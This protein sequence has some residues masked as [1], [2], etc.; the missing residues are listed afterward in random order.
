MDI[1]SNDLLGTNEFISLPDNPELSNENKQEF[2]EYYEKEQQIKTEEKINSSINKIDLKNITFNE[3]TDSNNL[4]NTNKYGNNTIDNSNMIRSTRDVTTLVSVDSRDRIKT[5]YP[6]PNDF[7]IFLG[8][9]YRNVKKIEL[10]SLEFPNTDAVI[11]NNNNMIYW[12]NKEDID[13][14]IT[15]TIKGVIYYPVYSAKLRIGS[16]TVSSLQ[17][18][19]VKELTV[20]KRQEGTQNG[21]PTNNINDFHFFVVNLDI[22][23]DIVTFNSLILLNLA[24][25]AIS[26]LSGTGVITVTTPTA[27]GYENDSLIYMNGAKQVGGISASII[28]G[29]QLIT[30]TDSIT[31]KF[32]LNVNASST[33]FGG[34]NTIQSGKKAPFQLLWGD[35]S[36]TIAQNIGYPLENSSSTIDTNIVSLQNFFQ[37]SI[38]L[39]THNPSTSNLVPTEPDMFF[40]KTYDY[41]G[42]TINIGSYIPN[43]T[44]FIPYKSFLIT[45]VPTT[46]SIL[47]QI[48]DNTVVETMNNS[49][50]SQAYIIQ[51]DNTTFLNV[52]FYSNYAINS[53]LITTSSPH[54]YDLSNIANTITLI[55]TAD[56]TIPND[57]S[58]DGTYI[59][60]QVPSST[61]LAVQGVIGNLNT[62]TSGL[63][64]HL[65]RHNAIST[66][67]VTIADII[68]NFLIDFDGNV[69]AKIVTI[70]PHKLQVNDYIFFN[71]LKSVPISSI[72]S[73]KIVTIPDSSSFLIKHQFVSIDTTTILN[74]TA[75]IGTGLI[76]VSFPSHNFNSII[77]VIQGP[78]IPVVN[79]YITILDG[80]QLSTT[81]TIKPVA[82]VSSGTVVSGIV[83][84]VTIQT[85]TPHNLTPGSVVRIKF[86]GIEPVMGR[87]VLS[88]GY[89]VYSVTSTDTFTIVDINTP[90]PLYVYVEPGSINGI[91]GLSSDFYLYGVETVGGINSTLLNSISFTVR[92]VL[93]SDNF[94]FMC[95]EFATSST[96]GGGSIIYISSLL[97]GFSGA[98]T[99]TKNNILNRSINLEGENYAF[100]T[101]PQLDTMVN[102]GNVRNV[103]ARISLD[104]PPGYVCFKYLS[105]PKTFYT[106]PLNSLENLQFSVVN[107]NTSLYEFSD[108][109]WAFCLE[110]TEV[111]DT[112][113]QFNISSRRGITDSFKK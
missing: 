26:T 28:N 54:N 85:M 17:T 106:L 50:L 22:N 44:D 93:D 92:S 20:V 1:D 63:Y 90:F 13:Q 71:N 36:N 51:F 112:N 41:I 24:N 110:I 104:Q 12:R 48:N 2:R 35:Y 40:L 27:H 73:Y 81:P 55:D 14:D 19:I 62:H 38:T 65:N 9:T 86:S 113:D 7:N 102:T 56:N 105:N 57:P 59:I 107:Y 82:S 84:S 99:N 60:S 23:T 75:F 108:L 46:T 77:N 68:P 91:I 80:N 3:N 101:C 42:H 98:Q 6:K 47:V 16:Y 8:K 58:Y 76:T 103:F 32:T 83:Y 94:T 109:D 97:H 70:V 72:K 4:L 88:G 5:I 21:S 111:I 29:F 95:N 61:T 87:R 25:N 78:D 15:V 67:T 53:F 52:S 31:F 79:Q 39:T 96:V 64:G 18:E 10:V 66:W 74:G 69:Y 33:S 89:I 30:V 49:L 43:T 11:N 45:D 37:M 100:I 34:G